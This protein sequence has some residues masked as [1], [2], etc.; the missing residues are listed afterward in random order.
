MADENTQPKLTE[1]QMTA[2]SALF[3]QA[4]LEPKKM[5]EFLNEPVEALISVGMT[6]EDIKNIADY[7]YQFK[8]N[9]RDTLT[10]YD[11]W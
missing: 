2:I 7:F 9:L 10:L 4:L 3:T 8:A 11:P 5:V 6:H 1:R